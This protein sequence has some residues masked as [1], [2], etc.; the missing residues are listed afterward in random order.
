[1][2]R[3]Q[4][5]YLSSGWR[6][7][8]TRKQE[9][10]NYPGAENHLVAISAR[11]NRSKGARGPEEWAP[12]DEGLWCQYAVD[13]TKIKDRWGLSMTAAETQAM[14]EMLGTCEDPPEVEVLDHLGSV[15]WED[16][17]VT[18][19]DGTV[20]GSCDEA[21]A[22]GEERVQGSRGGGKGFPAE[23]VP[24]ARDGD[25]DGVVCEN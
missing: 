20:Y 10:A 5:A 8:A 21:T 17:A 12:P 16:K 6:W 25:G 13:W 24:R 2:V 23:M 4:N 15:T 9:Y 19:P 14:V 3:L 1:M 22:A 18:G 7:D 11:H